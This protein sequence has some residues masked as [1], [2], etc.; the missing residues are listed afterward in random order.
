MSDRAVPWRADGLGELRAL[1]ALRGIAA[2]AVVLGHFSTTAQQLTTTAI[3]RLVPRSHMAVDFFFVLSGF[4]MSYTY[5]TAFRAHRPGAYRDFLA[6]RFARIMPLHITMIL[7]AAALGIASIALTGRNMFW[8]GAFTWPDLVANFLLLPGIGIGENYN[9]PTWS[10]STEM[11][12]YLAFPFLAAGVFS[13]QRWIAG[14]TLGVVVAV[15]GLLATNKVR[16][17]LD[18]W[19]GPTNVLRCFAEFAL[20]MIAFRSCGSAQLRAILS[21]D[22]AAV[23]LSIACA[24][25]LLLRVDLPAALMFP[26]LVIAFATNTSRAG[27]ALAARPLHFLGVVSYSIYLIHFPLGPLAETLAQRLL[28]A[29]A[30]AAAAIAFAFIATAAVVP[31]AW[32]AFEIIERPGRDFVRRLFSTAPSAASIRRPQEAP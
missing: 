20:G 28:E 11:I 31:C 15:L 23:L 27:G 19:E 8:D 6:R 9:L 25:A 17:S 2:L 30:S 13:Q 24:A 4:I 7:V 14:G 26:F 29:N 18:Y 22:S 1:T 10:I 21:R 3:P 5:L 32:L 12:A 16:L